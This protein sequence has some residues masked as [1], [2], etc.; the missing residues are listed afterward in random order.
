VDRQADLAGGYARAIGNRGESFQ[1]VFANTAASAIMV[2]R[3]QRIREAK[4]V[5]EI[6]TL[7]NSHM[8]NTL[9]GGVDPATGQRIPGTLDTPFNPKGEDGTKGTSAEEATTTAHAEWMQDESGPLRKLAPRAQESFKQRVA[10]RFESF[11]QTARERDAQNIAARSKIIDEAASESNKRFV[12]MAAG[13]ITGTKWSDANAIGRTQHAMRMTRNIQVDPGNNDP[14]KLAFRIPEGEALFNQKMREFDAESASQRVGTLLQMADA[15]PIGTPENDARA[16]ALTDYAVN[17]AQGWPK[18]GEPILTPDAIAKAKDAAQK[19]AAER[20]RRIAYQREVNFSEAKTVAAAIVKGTERDPAKLEA[21]ILKLE[22]TH[23]AE[24]KRFTLDARA[25]E[26]K[27]QFEKSW[28]SYLLAGHDRMKAANDEVENTIAA[29]VTTEGRTHAKKMVLDHQSA[30]ESAAKSDRA[31]A[32]AEQREREE[33]EKEA[34][35]ATRTAS[36]VALDSGITLTT[37]GQVI[38]IPEYDQID[39]GLSLLKSGAITPADFQEFKANLGKK[40]VEPVV[41]DRVLKL[42]S[43]KLGIENAETLF[44]YSTTKNGFEL[45][46]VT[47][48]GKQQPVM[49]PTDEAAVLKWQDEK[50]KARK[51]RLSA[52]IVGDLL[53]AAMAYEMQVKP[54]DTTGRPPMSL[55]E[56]LSS[57]LAPETNGAVRELMEQNVRDNIEENSGLLRDIQAMLSEQEFRAAVQGLEKGKA[58]AND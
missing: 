36:K 58:N 13:D 35:R 31:E 5:D 51:T 16:K 38:A 6:E 56:H 37:D 39:Q 2:D 47:K 1:N 12:A 32:K 41:A 14:A 50:G 55:E 40:R 33:A 54:K 20:T 49:D 57:M 17:F 28:N 15:E 42:I 29:M 44:D 27:I 48:K 43:S 22:P 25:A 24:L 52:Q 9:T 18:E 7:W 34:A 21:A 46:T 45:A 23:R 3:V 30:Q 19:I 11:R 8:F 10:N 4:Q 26:D 53:N